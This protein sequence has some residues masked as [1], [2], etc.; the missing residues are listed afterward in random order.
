MLSERSQRKAN[1]MSS[2][3][4]LESQKGQQTSDYSKEV[5]KQSGVRCIKKIA[6]TTMSNT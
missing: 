6:P 3:L 1:T 5:S 4:H 2:H